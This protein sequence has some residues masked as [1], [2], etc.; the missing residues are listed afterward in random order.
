MFGKPQRELFNTGIIDSI[1][2]LEIKFQTLVLMSQ[3]RV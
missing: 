1:K 3:P 2:F